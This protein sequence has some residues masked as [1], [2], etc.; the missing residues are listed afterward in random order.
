[1][2]KI[3]E[4]SFNIDYKLYTTIISNRLQTIVSD[5]IDEDPTGFVLGRRTQDNIRRVRT[6][7]YK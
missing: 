1:M 5:L 7:H 6:S 4:L 2:F 3:P